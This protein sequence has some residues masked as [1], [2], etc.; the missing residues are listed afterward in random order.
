MG[1]MTSLQTNQ[2]LTTSTTQR[3]N[4]IMSGKKAIAWEMC[5]P[6]QIDVW[7]RN[8]AFFNPIEIS[9]KLLVET[10]QETLDLI[11]RHIDSS[12][13]VFEQLIAQRKT[14]F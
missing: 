12:C 5:A 8:N 2:R 7:N 4:G 9:K 10:P 3:A 13:D 14:F 1:A 11:L 6:Y